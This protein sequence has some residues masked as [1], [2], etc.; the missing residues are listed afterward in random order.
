MVNPQHTD[1]AKGDLG[2]G[3][4][5]S[6]NSESAQKASKLARK[7]GTPEIAEG[8]PGKVDLADR[9]SPEDRPGSDPKNPGDFGHH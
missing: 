8:G 4:T 5:A 1:A 6:D 7:R 2:Q 9:G 3:K